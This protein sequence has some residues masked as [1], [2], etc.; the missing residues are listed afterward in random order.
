MDPPLSPSSG[1]CALG[2]RNA[3][4]LA[5]HRP[6]INE[7]SEPVE[8]D[9]GQSLLHWAACRVKNPHP[10]SEHNAPIEQSGVSDRS[11]FGGLGVTKTRP[12]ADVEFNVPAH[13]MSMF[14]ELSGLATQGPFELAG[15]SVYF[16]RH[17]S[18]ATGQVVQGS[19]RTDGAGLIT[20]G[21]P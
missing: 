21:P 1:T 16:E 15:L 14:T 18:N 4:S 11:G 20:Q 5:G 2:R 13:D 17:L 6:S 8:N 9:H 7:R 3:L 19:S 12:F 10:V